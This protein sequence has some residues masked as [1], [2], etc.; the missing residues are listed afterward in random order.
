MTSA[1]TIASRGPSRIRAGEAVLVLAAAAALLWLV[2]NVPPLG[3]RAFETEVVLDGAHYRAGPED[4]RWLESFTSLHFGEGEEAARALVAAEVDARLDALFDDAGSRLPEFF[5][6]YYS[7]RGEY[8]RM[9]MAALQTVDLAEPGYVAERAASILLPEEA[10]AS[11]LAA[12]ER[13]A[14]DRIGAHQDMLR[15]TW[16]AAV[17]E[18]LS[19]H[20]VPA[21]LGDV[22]QRPTL[23]LDDLLGEIVAREAGALDARLSISTA[24]AVGAA[25]APALARAAAVRGGRAAAGRAAAR[26]ASRIGAAAVS[27]AAVCAPGGPVAAA[28]AVLAGAGAW[29]VTDWALLRI[30]EQLHREQLETAFHEGLSQ[31]RSEIERELLVSFDEL[32]ASHYAAVQGEIRR[33]FVPAE[34]GRAMGVNAAIEDVPAP[35]VERAR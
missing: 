19:A 23:V 7:L 15:D 25:A 22:P 13:D 32:I 16:R 18:R 21:P 24:V 9:T 20:R 28:C 34:A 5:D 33:S 2:A 11:H 35:A 12:L 10:W 8:S 17:E 1:A 4:L 30:D 3:W 14:A 6:W 29:I 27:G 26:G 31:L